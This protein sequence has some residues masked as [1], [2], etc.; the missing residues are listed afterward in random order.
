MASKTDRATGGSSPSDGPSFEIRHLRYFV[1]V[2]EERNF[3]RAAERLGIAQP[4][5]SQQIAS[6][7]TILGTRLLDRRRRAFALTRAGQ[8]FLVEAR[9][10]LDQADAAFAAARKAARGET[11]QVSIGYVA[12]VA[13][14]AAF[15]DLI[16]AFRT[17]YPDVELLLTEMEMLRQI[18]RIGEGSLDVGFIRPPA[19]IPSGIGITALLGEPLVALLP[20][21]HPFATRDEVLLGGLSDET[22]IVPNQAADVGFHRQTILACRAAGIQPRIEPIGGDF[23][24]IASMVTVGLGIALVPR[25][26]ECMRLPGIVYRPVT[27]STVPTE[28]AMAYRRNESTPAAREFIDH[29]RQAAKVFAS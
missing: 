14:T 29:C 19:P 7:E 12:S 15:T 10:T 5:L 11:G 16:G 3:G 22:F 9:K 13:Y 6:L 18:E 4:G 20:M 23:M 24:T 27:P 8:V 17:A 2:V 26:M 28:I 25:S 21:R 1:T